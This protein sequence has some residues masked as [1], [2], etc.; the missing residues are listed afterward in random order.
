MKIITRKEAKALG[1][2]RY[3]TG[4]P[5]KRGHIC[6]RYVSDSCVECKKDYYQ[7]NKEQITEKQK[8]YHKINKKQITERNKEYYKSNR[9]QKLKQGKVYQKA[10]RKK[11]TVYQKEYNKVNKKYLTKQQKIYSESHKEEIAKRHKEYTKDNP[12]KYAAASAKRNAIKKL[13][14]PEWYEKKQVEELFKKRNELT[15]STGIKHEVDHI[16]PLQHKLVCGL[17]CFANLQIL[18]QSENRKKS[19]RYII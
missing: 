2:K 4:K 5:C 3:F 11:I 16:I 15:E 7:D 1:L 6:D 19:N 18:T 12:E 9:E 14:V 10:N 17:H 13:A 8:V